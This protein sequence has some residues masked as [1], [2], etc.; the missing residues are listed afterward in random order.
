MSIAVVRAGSADA[1]V[2][3]TILATGFAHDPVSAWIF[4]DEVERERLHPSFFGPFVDSV[5]TDGEVYTTEDRAGAALWLS[6]DVGPHPAGPA[7]G[8]L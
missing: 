6:V 2:V 3:T 4:P 1:Q 7:L 5:L 8:E